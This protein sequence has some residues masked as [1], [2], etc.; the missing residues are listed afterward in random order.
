LFLCF[1][2]S[3]PPAF[4]TFPSSYELSSLSCPDF[5]ASALKIIPKSKL[6]RFSKKI[7][8]ISFPKHL[9]VLVP[10]N[11]PPPN[12]TSK[13]NNIIK[14]VFGSTLRRLIEEERKIHPIFFWVKVVFRIY[15]S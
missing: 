2:P 4:L 15:F 8:S 12:P 9:T 3:S 1:G 13:K 11:S 14:S 6:M 10:L 7:I 5:R